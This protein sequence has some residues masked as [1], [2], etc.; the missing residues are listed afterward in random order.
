MA[1]ELYHYRQQRRYFLIPW[2]IAYLLIGI[3]YIGKPANKH[4]MERRAYQIQWEC[5]RK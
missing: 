5:Q 1:H 4:P 2:L 3:F